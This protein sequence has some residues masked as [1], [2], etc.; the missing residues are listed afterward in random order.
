M[1]VFQIM[2]QVLPRTQAGICIRHLV[3][4]FDMPHQVIK[5]E[6]ISMNTAA[7]CTSPAT[8]EDFNSA[9]ACQKQH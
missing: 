1:N 9:K 3:H 8:S 7:F 6:K 2:L 5:M 4:I